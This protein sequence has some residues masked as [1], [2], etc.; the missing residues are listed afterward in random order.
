MA[1][2][3]K[4]EHDDVTVGE[5]GDVVV[6]LLGSRGQL[7]IPNHGSVPPVF[8]KPAPDSVDVAPRQTRDA[9]CAQ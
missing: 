1:Y 4:S 8:A 2:I 3:V 6:R 5:N 9:I 7:K